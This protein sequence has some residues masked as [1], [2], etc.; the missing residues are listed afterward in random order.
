M[1]IARAPNLT[2]VIEDMKERGYW[3]A[4]ASGTAAKTIWEEDWDRPL[5]IVIG[6]EEAGIRPAVEK[7]C[8]FSVRIPISGHVESLNAS[9]SA[10]VL[11]FEI[12]RYRKAPMRGA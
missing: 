12:Q 7:A 2:R 5:G 4:A 1:P 6:N 10:A 9:V 3:I 11:L 8:D